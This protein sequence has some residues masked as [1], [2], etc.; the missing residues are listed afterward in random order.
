MHRNSL[1]FISGVVILLIVAGFVIINQSENQSTASLVKG[2]SLKGTTIPE[3]NSPVPTGITTPLAFATSTPNIVQVRGTPI[4][5]LDQAEAIAR[6]TF[7]QFGP[8][9]INVTYQKGDK[10]HQATYGFE[11][12]KNNENIVQ[13]SIEPDTGSISSYAIGIKR[14]GRPEKP[15][16]TI[17][18]GQNTAKKEITSRNGEIS[19]NITEARYDPLGFPDRSIA[20]VYVY[21]YE[22]LIKNNPCDSDGFTVDVDSISGSVVEYRKTWIKPPEEI[23]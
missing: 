11:L 3:G 16:I 10:Q 2:S 13:G 20:G 8:D 15:V 4:I 6:E 1:Y 19:L 9:R 23:C 18:A 21:V 22:R 17:E 14:I 5:A 7:S 12:F